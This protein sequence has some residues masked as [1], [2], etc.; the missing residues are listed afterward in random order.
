M[1]NL[2]AGQRSRDF[3]SG[4]TGGSGGGGTPS[5]GSLSTASGGTTGARSEGM[6]G[7]S[8]NDAAAAAAR[9]RLAANPNAQRDAARARYLRVAKENGVPPAESYTSWDAGKLND[10]ADRIEQ[11]AARAAAE[12]DKA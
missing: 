4:T 2:C 10:Y 5:A 12:A 8:A 6:R 1:G 3:G 9:E 11:M 7:L